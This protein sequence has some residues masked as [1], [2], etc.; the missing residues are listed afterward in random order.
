[1]THGLVVEVTVNMSLG[2]HVRGTDLHILPFFC[3]Y[4]VLSHTY[5]IYIYI[6]IYVCVCV[7]VIFGLTLD[8][9]NTG[10]KAN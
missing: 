6:Y 8:E 3:E 10:P 7:Y 5:Y 1:M 9:F 2:L 4:Q